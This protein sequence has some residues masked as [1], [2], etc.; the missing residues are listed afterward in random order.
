MSRPRPS[1]PPPKTPQ[2]DSTVWYPADPLTIRNF[3]AVCW[4]TGRDLFERLG[5]DV[6]VGLAM[7]AVGAHPIESWLGPDQL[8]ACG[9]H[10]FNN[11]TNGT[12]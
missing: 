3:S 1:R 2:G 7:N 10:W 9:L 4:L 11:G 6:P 5:G 8:G 12:M